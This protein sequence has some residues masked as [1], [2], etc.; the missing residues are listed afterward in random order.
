MAPKAS[1]RLCSRG[2]RV[3]PAGGFLRALSRPGA[4]ERR[5]SLRARCVG[6]ERKTGDPDLGVTEEVGAQAIERR[7]QSTAGA[8]ARALA[9]EFIKPVEAG[10]RR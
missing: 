10:C 3:G 1:L 2:E 8:A 7:R 4:G 9:E 5:G 6:Q